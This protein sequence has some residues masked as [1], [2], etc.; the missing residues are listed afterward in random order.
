MYSVK[1]LTQDDCVPIVHR[2]GGGGQKC[3]FVL[4]F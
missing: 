2:L 1:Q 3:P 4:R